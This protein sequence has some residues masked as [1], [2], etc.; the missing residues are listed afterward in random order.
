MP[1]PIKSGTSPIANPYEGLALTNNPFPGDPIIRPGSKDR[2]T[3]GAIFADGCRKEVISRFEKLLLRGTDFNGRARMALLWSEGD[4]ETGRGTGKT[5]LLRHFQHRINRDWGTAEFKQF[6]AAVIYVCFP[7]MV[8]RLFSEQLAWAALLDAE[9]SGLIRA[10][11]AMLRLAE[12]QKRWADQSGALLEE[13]NRAES[14]GH[15]TVDVL[16][17]NKVLEGTGLA[18]EDVV[19]AV[20][21]RLTDAGVK[22]AVAEAL[23]VA[24]LSGHLRS[25]RKDGE[26][27][28]YY[29]PRET[30]GLTHAKDLLFN[31]VVRFLNEAGFAGAYLFI[32]DVENLTDQ[33]ANKETIKFAKELAMCL[34]RPGRA[35]ADMRFFSFVLTTHQQAA[36]KL[37]RGWGEAGLQAVARLDQMADTSVKVPLPSEDGA[38]EM[39]AEYIKEH[40]LPGKDG[41]QWLHPFTEAAARKLVSGVKPALH[42]RT[43]LQKAHFAVRQAA[44]DRLKSIEVAD[45]EKLLSNIGVDATASTGEPVTFDTY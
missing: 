3:N 7:D 40:R 19:S 6:S 22:A 45:I 12:I 23:A 21:E 44:D 32:D 34:A 16:L 33:M 43:F 38:L 8:D 15:D 41:L 4:K 24:N 30:K 37:A 31:D 25:L 36:T 14:A 2:R 39:L 10:A 42:P 1:L 27:R 9:E 5:A 26:V 13:M 29:V 18:V 35:S 28:P 17:D 20:V 11:S